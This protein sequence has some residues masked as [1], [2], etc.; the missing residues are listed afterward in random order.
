MAEMIGK[1]LAHYQV[2]REIGRGAMG[3]VYLARGTRRRRFERESLA[4]AA[5][6]HANIVTIHAV[7]EA[8]GQP[9]LVMEWIA[10]RTLAELIPAGGLAPD[11]FFELATPLAA[12]VAQAHRAGIVHRDLKPGNV[13]VRDDGVLK[14]VDFGISLIEPETIAEGMSELTAGL[15]AGYG[16]RLTGEGVAVGTLPYMSP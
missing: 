6:N 5:L 9:F 4:L 3:Q 10:G 13:M 14:V 11:P 16:E 2:L 8:E 15:P 1:T 7:E 12:A